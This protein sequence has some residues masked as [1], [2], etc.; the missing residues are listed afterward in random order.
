MWLPGKTGFI[1]STVDND[2]IGCHNDIQNVL[3]TSEKEYCTKIN[4]LRTQALKR[5]GCVLY[6]IS[7][8]LSYVNCIFIITI[9]REFSPLKYFRMKAH[10]RKLINIENCA[11]V[12]MH[13]QIILNTAHSNFCLRDF[14]LP[15]IC[16]SE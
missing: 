11:I 3:T 5:T 1:S 9:D 8:M 12:K 6:G 14:W 7:Q 2:G 16:L 4:R 13:V 10:V 15:E